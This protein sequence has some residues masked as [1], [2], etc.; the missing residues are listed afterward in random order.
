MEKN[1][2]RKVDELVLL[3]IKIF[4]KKLSSDFSDPG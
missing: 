1:L 4:F 2:I 3:S